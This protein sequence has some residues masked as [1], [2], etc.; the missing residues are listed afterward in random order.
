MQNLSLK[1]KTGKLTS[2]KN[3]ERQTTDCEA[4][5]EFMLR[6]ARQQHVKISEEPTLP[7][8]RHD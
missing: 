2:P 3:R 8:Y 4:I 7:K 6:L 1:K 5:P